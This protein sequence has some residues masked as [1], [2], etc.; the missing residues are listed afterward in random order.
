MVSHKQVCTSG[1]IELGELRRICREVVEAIADFHV[2]VF[3]RGV[4]TGVT[5]REVRG[6]VAPQSSLSMANLSGCH[7]HTGGLRIEPEAGIA[8][9]FGR[10]RRTEQQPVEC[11]TPARPRTPRLR[12][13]SGA[14]PIPLLLS[15][16]AEWPE[17]SRTIPRRRLASTNLT[18]ESRRRFSAAASTW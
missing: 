2:D 8:R 17:G 1:E 10:T 16:R 12:G 5:P 4:P 14:G 15:L 3:A 13:A 11:A 18:R 7:S 9:R 6:A